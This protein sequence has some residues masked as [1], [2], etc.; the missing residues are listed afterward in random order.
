MYA[1]WIELFS[2]IERKYDAILLCIMGHPD[3]ILPYTILAGVNIHQTMHAN[4]FLISN[5]VIFIKLHMYETLRINLRM[6][7]EWIDC[8]SLWNIIK[9]LMNLQR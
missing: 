2:I 9:S 4:F 5:I 8:G 6:K 7:D 3:R 1:E